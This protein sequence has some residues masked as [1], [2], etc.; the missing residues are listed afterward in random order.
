VEV[1][2]VRRLQRAWGLAVAVAVLTA[3]AFAQTT[4][5]AAPVMAAPAPPAEARVELLEQRVVSLLA[6]LAA[7]KADR[8]RLERLLTRLVSQAERLEAD[9]LLLTELRKEVP[10]L[11]EEAEQY[12][13]RLRRLALVSDPVRLAPV[14]ARM[15][16]ASPI[17]LNWRHT[18]Y[19]TADARTRAYA[20][21]G[22]HGFPAAL[23]NFRQ[24]VLLTVSNR[25]EGFLILIE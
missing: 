25:L 2:R 22:A 9:R 7:V 15:A 11:R 12:V 18:T 6:E 14:A 10:E 13:A 4:P 21:S 19:P 3:P 17:F 8:D 1:A 20:E 5:A 24:A 16:D 23:D